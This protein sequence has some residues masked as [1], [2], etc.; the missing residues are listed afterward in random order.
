MRMSGCNL[1][2][3]SRR[4]AVITEFAR[5]QLRAKGIQSKWTFCLHTEL[6]SCPTPPPKVQKG[7]SCTAGPRLCFLSLSPGTLGEYF[8]P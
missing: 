4:C 8:L 2:L 7:S 5:I 3:V 6:S 1:I